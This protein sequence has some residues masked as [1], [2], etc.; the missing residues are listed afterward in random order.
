MRRNFLS[1]RSSRLQGFT[2]IEILVVVAILGVLASIGLFSFLPSLEKGRDARRKA[3][4]ENLTKVLEAYNTDHGRYPDSVDGQID[5][6]GGG[7]TCPWGSQFVDEKNTVYM[8]E[9]PTDPTTNEYFYYSDGSGTWY[10]VLARLENETDPS[11]P[12]ISDQR[13]I[14]TLAPAVLSTDCGGSG[15]GYGV[16]SPGGSLGVFNLTLDDQ[17][18]SGG[19]GW[20]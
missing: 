1:N 5:C 6:R 3:D 2:M 8:A 16:T 19:P 18:A 9:L 12:S 11:W 4:L 14:Y 15:C 7:S 20:E 17:E 10:A 13:A